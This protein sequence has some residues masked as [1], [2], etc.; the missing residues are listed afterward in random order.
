VGAADRNASRRAERCGRVLERADGDG[1]AKPDVTAPGFP[2]RAARSLFKS[3]PDLRKKGPSGRDFMQLSG[4]SMAAGVTTGV[5]AL[6]EQATGRALTPNLAKG[7]LQ[8]TAIP[9]SDD[10]GD[11]FSPLQQGTGEI[12]AQGSL[13]LLTP[14]TNVVELNQPWLTASVDK[15]TVIGTENYAWAGNIVRATT[16]SG[17]FVVLQPAGLGP[18]HCLG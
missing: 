16:S 2:G 10:E 18:E 11:R 14:S 1:L 13:V 8:F 12:N 7:V 15:S 3:Y 4:T 5:V 9:M 17:R 6:L